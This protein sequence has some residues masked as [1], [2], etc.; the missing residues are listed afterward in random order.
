MNLLAIDPGR[1]TG[2]ARY[3]DGQLRECGVTTVDDLQGPAF[4]LILSKMVGALVIEIPQVYRASMSKGDPNDLIKVA[5]EAGRWIERAKLAGMDVTCTL[6]NEWKGQVP[7]AIHH[8][9]AESTLTASERMNLPATLC[10]SKR[11]NAMDAV[12][13]G[14]W[15]LARLRR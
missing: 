8:K 12:A 3:V 1:C 4:T 5:I 10:E 2:Y 11:H 15:R 14:L 13:L 9:R 6:P 7:K